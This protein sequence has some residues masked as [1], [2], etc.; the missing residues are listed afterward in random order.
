[1]TWL[2]GVDLAA[3]AS[4]TTDPPRQRR[5][6]SMRQAVGRS[7]AAA[8]AIVVVLVTATMVVAVVRRPK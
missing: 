3:L 2:A 1:V 8:L 4:E 7:V 5:V 6:G